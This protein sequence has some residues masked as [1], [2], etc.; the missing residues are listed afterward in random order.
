M[1]KNRIF[2]MN[3]YEYYEALAR[4]AEVASLNNENINPTV[5]KD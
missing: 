1:T 3:K 2:E 5:Q 4:I